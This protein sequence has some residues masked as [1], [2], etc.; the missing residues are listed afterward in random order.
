MKFKLVAAEQCMTALAMPCEV[1]E[2]CANSR[3]F[4]AVYPA[5]GVRCGV[6]LT[7]NVGEE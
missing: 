1:A 5:Q 4:F 2:Q 6:V 3:Y 7:V